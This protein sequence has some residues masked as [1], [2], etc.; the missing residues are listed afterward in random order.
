MHWRHVES[1]D[2]TAASSRT[3]VCGAAARGRVSCLGR[4]RCHYRRRR[5]SF[6]SLCRCAWLVWSKSFPRRLLVNLHK[7]T[8][9]RSATTASVLRMDLWHYVYLSRLPS[10]TPL[11][12]ASTVSVRLLR[13]LTPFA[14]ARTCDL[15]MYD[16]IQRTSHF[17]E[18][19]ILPLKTRNSSRTSAAWSVW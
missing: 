4:G 2:R 8:A 14:G 12:R 19:S 3:P 17:L 13:F 11:K 6:M 5:S 9:H 18:S 7:T 16:M 1:V 10:P 15:Q